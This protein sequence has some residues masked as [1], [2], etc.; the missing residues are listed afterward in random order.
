MYHQFSETSPSHLRLMAQLG[1]DVQ[2]QMGKSQAHAS[3]LHSTLRT[4][5]NTHAA[6]H[7]PANPQ[8]VIQR[9]AAS[10]IDRGAERKYGE[11]M[12]ALQRQR[13]KRVDSRQEAEQ[14]RRISEARVNGGVVSEEDD[15]EM[16]DGAPVSPCSLSKSL[17]VGAFSRLRAGLHSFM[18]AQ[19]SDHTDDFAT[20]YG[21]PAAHVA[22]VA[23]RPAVAKPNIAA[24]TKSIEA[25]RQRVEKTLGFSP[26]RHVAKKI[27]T[28]AT[29][30]KAVSATGSMRGATERALPSAEQVQGAAQMALVHGALTP[31]QC[32]VLDTQLALG[33][34][35][36]VPMDIMN[37]LAGRG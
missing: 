23:G 7:A 36:A 28:T 18:K 27:A 9:S 34:P 22:H 37:I 24:L 5:G 26:M 3:L 1:Y 6:S 11:R 33:G 25:R 14:L 20:R 29:L 17:H 32:S 4:A 35:A 31:A 19:S 10:D 16:V 8:R 30:A 12:T 13:A 15:E 21:M 2:A